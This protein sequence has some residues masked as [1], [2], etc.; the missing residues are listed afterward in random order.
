LFAGSDGRLTDD[1]N[2]ATGAAGRGAGRGGRGGRGGAGRGRGGRGRGNKNSAA[3]NSPSPEAA[4]LPSLSAHAKSLRA[5]RAVQA[6]STSRQL[7][8][9]SGIESEDGDDD[10]EWDEDILRPAAP[11]P[12]G[13]AAVA[14]LIGGPSLEKIPPLARPPLSL[15]KISAENDRKTSRSDEA[16]DDFEENDMPDSKRMVSSPPSLLLLL[17]PPQRTTSPAL[18]S[19]N[20]ASLMLGSSSLGEG[21]VGRALR[22]RQD[23]PASRNSLADDDDDEE[24]LAG[25]DDEEDEEEEYDPYTTTML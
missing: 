16:H 9:K 14:S 4:A 17:T 1:E 20:T 12:G 5:L 10:L 8:E 2:I 22:P 7:L 19:Q 25:E 15:P 6:T 24:G 11:P 18:Q 23:P 3:N 21:S 13:G